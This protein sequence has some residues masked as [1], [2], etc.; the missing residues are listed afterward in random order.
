M[1]WSS[2]NV[3][4]QMS[5]RFNTNIFSFHAHYVVR[6]LRYINF[7]GI[8]ITINTIIFL[9]WHVLFIICQSTIMY[10]RFWLI[11]MIYILISSVFTLVQFIPMKKFRNI[12]QNQLC[13][14]QNKIKQS[15]GLNIV[16]WNT[17]S[18]IRNILDA[19]YCL[20]DYCIMHPK[21]TKVRYWMW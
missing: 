5:I 4:R 19:I 8:I 16:H 9:A 12:M 15:S 10:I 21:F 11:A 13:K 17:G 20:C 6:G 1:S 14:L 2:I 3:C 18:V 7:Y